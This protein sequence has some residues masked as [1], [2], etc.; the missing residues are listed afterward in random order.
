MIAYL[1]RMHLSFRGTA[2]RRPQRCPPMA[3]SCPS[4]FVCVCS[5]WTANM[6]GRV[7]FTLPPN[8][9][10][11]IPIVMCAMLTCTKTQYSLPPHSQSHCSNQCP[12][13]LKENYSQDKELYSYTR[14]SIH[15]LRETI[16]QHASSREYPSSLYS[17]QPRL[18]SLSQHA[19]QDNLAPSHFPRSELHLKLLAALRL[20]QVED[21]S[22]VHQTLLYS[23][24]TQAEIK[25]GCASKS[26]RT[27]S[28]AIVWLWLTV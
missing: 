24:Q 27:S 17:R 26:L 3:K 14:P 22:P 1:T 12:T 7:R 6:F 9:T 23:I 4:R 11:I 19:C 5:P 21:I 13:S 18:S 10:S 8:S 2:G 20:P 28:A 25:Q 15:D 16:Y